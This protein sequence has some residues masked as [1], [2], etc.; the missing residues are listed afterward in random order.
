MNGLCGLGELSVE[1][2]SGYAG[3]TNSRGFNFAGPTALPEE[4]C[5]SRFSDRN[6]EMRASG[7]QWCAE[8][9]FRARRERLGREGGAI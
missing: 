4:I 8:T 6:S 3:S 5:D 7:R 1:I 2:G 9:A